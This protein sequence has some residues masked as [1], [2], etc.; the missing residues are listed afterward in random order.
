MVQ[1]LPPK[2]IFT[3]IFAL[4]SS[5]LLVIPA[6][7]AAKCLY[8]SSYH[9]GYEWND[10][11]ERGIETGLN[12]KCELDRFYMDTKRNKDQTYGEKIALQAKAYIEQSKPDILIAADDNASRYLIQPYYKNSHLPVVFCGIN[13]SGTPY[14]YP[15]DNA[16][17]M[18][19]ISPVTPLVKLIKN[20]FTAMKHGIFLGPDVISQHREFE[21]NRERYAAKGIRI[22]PIFVK[23]MSEWVKGYHQ[24][25]QDSDFLI[26]GNNGGIEGWNDNLARHTALKEYKILSVTSYDWM[27]RYA[28]LAITKDA[29]EQGDWAARVAI[30]VLEGENI[31]NI[32]IIANRRWNIFVNSTL[33]NQGNITLPRHLMLKAI[34]ISL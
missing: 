26:V 29:E 8:I 24:A 22:T 15:Y 11:I 31:K 21:L 6:A 30:A 19:E 14:G 17:G 34:K 20:Q 5:S 25:Q 28:M 10:G 27:N 16:T 33:L 4:L 1:T 23:N 2:T 18:L 7:N 13:F 32:P 3:A 9:Q 12:G